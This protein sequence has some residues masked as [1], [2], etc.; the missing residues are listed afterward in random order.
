[1]LSSTRM[2]PTPTTTESTNQ[3][4][5]F[6][7]SDAVEPSGKKRVRRRSAVKNITAPQPTLIEFASWSTPKNTLSNAQG[8]RFDL[9]Q[10]ADE[11][12]KTYFRG[13]LTVNIRW[14]R[15]TNR[16]DDGKAKSRRRRRRQ[17]SVSIQLGSFDPKKRVIRIHPRLDADDV[18]NYVVRNV[19]YHEMLHQFLG[20]ERHGERLTF[21]SSAFR[22]LE[23]KCLDFELAKHWE[24]TVLVPSLM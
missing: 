11:V 12:N 6:E 7:K 17:R 21:H 1:M 2:S 4:T 15:K 18:P 22:E 23:K 8:E 20:P 9:E 13:R 16:V 19:V 14:G 10:I 5:L 3:L 24:D